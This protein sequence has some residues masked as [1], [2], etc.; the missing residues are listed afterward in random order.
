MT[1]AEPQ[2]GETYLIDGQPITVR[3]IRRNPGY[4]RTFEDGSTG[5][6]PEEI[7]ISETGSGWYI[8]GRKR[9]VEQVD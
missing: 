3:F 9:G 4:A 7:L 6:A 5:Q 1:S 2:L 8:W